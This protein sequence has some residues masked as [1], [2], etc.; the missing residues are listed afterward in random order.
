MSK[1]SALCAIISN[2]KNEFLLIK[3]AREPFKNQWALISGIGHTKITEDL[4]DAIK[5]EVKGD[6]GCNFEGKYLYTV[7]VE[8]DA[9]INKIIVYSGNIDSQKVKITKRLVS[10]Y[11]WRSKEEISALDILAFEHL[12]ILKKFIDENL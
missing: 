4:D 3:R 5:A 1:V 7:P 2:N 9:T 8:N 10:D 11:K 12:D 6:I